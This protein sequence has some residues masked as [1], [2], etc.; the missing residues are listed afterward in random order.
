MLSTIEFLV[1]QSKNGQ[2]CSAL[3]VNLQKLLHLILPEYLCAEAANGLQLTK[4]WLR[5]MKQAPFLL[6]QK[7]LQ[8][9]SMDPNPEN[10]FA[11]GISN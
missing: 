3:V 2:L 4:I 7:M 6:A 1:S 11:V 10:C 9:G 5:N 8:T